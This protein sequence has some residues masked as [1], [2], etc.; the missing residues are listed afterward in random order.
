MASVTKKNTLAF[1]PSLL[2]FDLFLYVFLTIHFALAYTFC[3]FVQKLLT[4]YAK[5]AIADT[6]SNKQ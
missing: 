1:F 4:V 6:S 3:I 2:H 5:K